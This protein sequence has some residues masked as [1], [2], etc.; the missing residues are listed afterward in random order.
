M[1]RIRRSCD[2]PYIH[3]DDLAPYT[4]GAGVPAEVMCNNEY[5]D[6][7]GGASFVSRDATLYVM[8]LCVMCY[9]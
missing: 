2:V 9:E 8:K 4:D 3:V 7:V 1:F 6:A 5:G